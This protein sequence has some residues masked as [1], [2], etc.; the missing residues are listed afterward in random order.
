MRAAAPILRVED[1]DVRFRGPG[2][3]TR[4][5]NGVS[6]DLWPGET[7]AIVGESGCGKSV[8]AMSVLR[9][10]PSPPGEIAGG[11]ILLADR[12]LRGMPDAE[13]R[14]LRGNEI[15]M[16]FQEPMTALN[17]VLTIGYQIGE[18]LMRHEGL[19]SAAAHARAVELLDFVRIPEPARRARQYPHQLSGGMRQRAMI[20]MALAC[21]PK[22]LIADEPTTALD[23][24]IQAQI[25]NLIVDLQKRLG[26]AVI[27]ITHDLGVVAETAH[28]V[29]VM[30]AGAKVEEAD[31]AELFARPLHP[32]TR[33]LLASVPKL[34]LGEAA[35][36]EAETRLAEIQGMVPPLFDLPSGC[37][38]AP[39]CPLADVTCHTTAP[40]LREI[41]SQHTVACHH[42][43]DGGQ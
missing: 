31:V 19:D 7:L 22:V 16:I 35:D 23:V 9:L 13:L 36:A 8:T 32:Y 29:L 1:L 18:A 27:L 34:A 30:Y 21:K 26:T 2:G 17:P 20:A 43:T 40:A 15:S 3:V 4:A 41:R 10:I 39:R 25:L 28:R 5:V 37:A 6:F 42:A 33:G 38:F 11:R 14:R 12:D 24:T